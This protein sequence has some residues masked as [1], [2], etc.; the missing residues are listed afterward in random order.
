MNMKNKEIN[1]KSTISAILLVLL[2]FFIALPSCMETT[3]PSNSNDRELSVFVYQLSAGV[4]GGKV[5]VR[6]AEVQ[7]ALSDGTGN[8]MSA[9][10]NSQGAAIFKLDVPLAGSNFNVTATY[11]NRSQSKLSALV[12]T[13]TTLIFIFDTTVVT[14]ID[15]GNLNSNENLVFID[16]NG[17]Q[18]LQ[19]NTPVNVNR[20]DRCSAGLY[21]SSREDITVNIP[22]VNAPFSLNLILVDGTP[23]E[24][25]N[26]QVVL[27]PGETLT[28]CFSVNT[29][30][31]GVFTQDLAISL[32]CSNGQAGIYNLNIKATV[33]EPQCDCEGMNDGFELSLADRVEV[34]SSRDVRN[35]VYTN[36]TPCPVTI[37][38]LSFDGNN[39]WQITA[40]QLPVTLQ[41]GA[42]LTLSA[43]FTALQAGTQIDTLQLE[44]IPEGSSLRCPY[45][46]EL[47][48]EGCSVSCPK[49]SFN[50]NNFS[51]FTG[52]AFPDTISDRNDKR[53]FVSVSSV[54]PQIL[55]TVTR[56]YYFMNPD[57]ACAD[58]DLNISVRFP[59]GDNYSPRFF[60]VSPQYLSLSPGQV[61]V[62]QVTFTSPDITEMASIVQSRGNTGKTA[63]S[64]FN[65][66][67]IV[68]SPG[69]EQQ[70]NA[71]TVVTAYPA[72]SPIINLRAYSQRTTLAPD[73]E[74]EIYYFGAGARNIIKGPGNSPG[75][76]PPPIGDIW[77]DVTDTLASA[78]PPLPPILKSVDGILGM[79]IWRVNMPE[80]QFTNVGF[81]YQQFLTDPNNSTGYTTGPLT[82]LAPGNVIAFQISANTYCLIYI[83][84]V[85]NGTENN[86][87]KQS[88]IEF[89]SIYPIYLP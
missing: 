2:S 35:I 21:N 23:A 55:T 74:N 7:I 26:N 46:V 47:I 12:C 69:C 36:N 32:L 27:K 88:G 8:P 49:I 11:N 33:E 70:I 82:G 84:S 54:D 1:K 34:G 62:V 86:T 83:R 30:V 3:S 38:R 20:Y 9:S 56:L 17:N 13:D 50:G 37:N 67:L 43:R 28:F 58:V 19:Q 51:P 42:S 25:K 18:N 75:P 68:Q 10:T 14:S 59:P 73:P 6:G 60:E 85:F 52:L 44:I 61:G 15:C 63:D 22:T 78:I 71:T 29:S 79:K 57:S 48:A 72:L 5:P 40:P 4:S 45:T 64:A 89:R 81:T 66:Q 41:P 65:I 24:I 87:N 53:V 76:Y 39:G 31:A 16:D 77:I 80:S